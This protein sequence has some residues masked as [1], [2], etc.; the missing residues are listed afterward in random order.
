MFKSKRFLA[1]LVAGIVFIVGTFFFEQEPVPFASALAIL[2]APYLAAQTF[3][4]SI[5]NNVTNEKD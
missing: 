4:S 2:L 5:T 3:R 1:T